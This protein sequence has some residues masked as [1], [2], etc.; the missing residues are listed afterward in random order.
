MTRAQSSWRGTC[1]LGLYTVKFTPLPWA[2]CRPG[3]P[4][5]RLRRLATGQ[6]KKECQDPPPRVY[7]RAPKSLAIDTMPKST[8]KKKNF[9]AKTKT[10]RVSLGLG[11]KIGQERNDTGEGGGNV[12]FSWRIGEDKKRQEKNKSD[13]V[14]EEKISVRLGSLPLTPPRTCSGT[15]LLWAFGPV[16]N[17]FRRTLRLGS[18]RFLVSS[19]FGFYGKR[20]F[21][22]SLR[23]P[24]LFQG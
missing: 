5:L 15:F 17:T 2:R 20:L 6:T 7:D 18:P 3:L 16:R 21:R 13:F 12:S 9:C 1:C 8:H 4:T 10:T 24:A 23:F 19:H 14:L 22:G 11:A